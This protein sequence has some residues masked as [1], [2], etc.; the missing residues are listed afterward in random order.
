MDREK[1]QTC[2]GNDVRNLL[3]HGRT[4]NRL[5]TTA[6]LYEIILGKSINTGK[7]KMEKYRENAIFLK[8]D[9]T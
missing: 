7:E 3:S 5:T 4:L 2:G 1:K 6:M 8:S 9:K